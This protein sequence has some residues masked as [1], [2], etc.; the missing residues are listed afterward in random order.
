MLG[1]SFAFG[2]RST[3][4]NSTLGRGGRWFFVLTLLYN[5]NKCVA[6]LPSQQLLGNCF[7]RIQGMS[8]VSPLKVNLKV[9]VVTCPL[10]GAQL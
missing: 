8:H 9:V 4:D 5:L 10:S 1:G 6:L 3:K 7:A 2:A